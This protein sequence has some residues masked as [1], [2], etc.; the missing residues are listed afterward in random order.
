MFSTFYIESLVPV[1]PALML[2]CPAEVAV[3]LVELQGA[4]L[5]HLQGAAQSK[6]AACCCYIAHTNGSR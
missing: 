4:E 1:H 2:L 3:I 5:K 6:T